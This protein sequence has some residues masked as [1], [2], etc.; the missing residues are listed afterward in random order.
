[1]NFADIPHDPKEVLHKEISEINEYGRDDGKM[2]VWNTKGF[3]SREN[4]RDG[5]RDGL[6]TRYNLNG[7]KIE[8]GEYK[9]ITLV[10]IKTGLWEEW[11]DNGQKREESNYLDG[12]LN[13]LWTR[14]WDNGKKE[15]EGNFKNGK[16]NGK[17]TTWFNDGVVRER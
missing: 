7:D 2:F 12:V 4:Y 3:L 1:M 16:K 15:S 14:W 10:S 13:G 11:Y 9:I 5:K 8:E 17:W 6:F